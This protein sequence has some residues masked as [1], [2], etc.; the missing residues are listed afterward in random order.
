[1]P[2]DNQAQGAK[3][4]K[5]KPK[6]GAEPRAAAG[7]VE[8]LES[9]SSLKLGIAQN[10]AEFVVNLDRTCPTS[11]RSGGADVPGQLSPVASLGYVLPNGKKVP[12]ITSS[13]ADP[14]PPQVA[15]KSH[16]VTF[17]N[18]CAQA[19]ALDV[20]KRLASAESNSTTA[21]SVDVLSGKALGPGR[22]HTVSVE[23]T[24]QGLRMDDAASMVDVEELLEFRINR[25]DQLDD[26]LI[27]L[28]G[29]SRVMNPDADIVRVTVVSE[30]FGDNDAR[31]EGNFH[32]LNFTQDFPDP[33]TF[34]T[35][36]ASAR[37]KS[38]RLGK[39]IVGYQGTARS[40]S[41]ATLEY[42]VST[43]GTGIG[44]DRITATVGGASRSIYVLAVCK[45]DNRVAWDPIITPGWRDYAIYAKGNGGLNYDENGDDAPNLA[46]GVA[47]WYPTLSMYVLWDFARNLPVTCSRGYDA[48]N[49]Y[50]EYRYGSLPAKGVIEVSRLPT[51]VL[52]RIRGE[53]EPKVAFSTL[54]LGIAFVREL[55]TLTRDFYQSYHNA[56]ATS[57][58]AIMRSI[59]RPYTAEELGE[60]RNANRQAK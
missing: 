32:V 29:G 13:T 52:K 19:V 4:S 47:I 42:D 48:D 40:S 28:E 7:D 24:Y 56:K 6:S 18:V 9:T 59:S 57:E 50:G 54:L 37:N 31:V 46:G 44:Y 35:A 55:I 20:K 51:L 2:K 22:S 21:A 39:K 14:R 3:K 41:I 5:G 38:I 11:K 10:K 30:Y 53:A 26:S 27:N 45:A 34:A 43:T 36:T 1:M 58:K 33:T 49:G 23:M 25:T 12:G 60:A 8:V 15:I 16:T 17:E